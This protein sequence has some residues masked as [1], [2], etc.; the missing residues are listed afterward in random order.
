MGTSFRVGTSSWFVWI[1]DGGTSFRLVF[2]DFG[3]RALVLEGKWVLG[4]SFGGKMGDFGLFT[5]TILWR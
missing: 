3:V 5:S 4:I 1:W 2:M